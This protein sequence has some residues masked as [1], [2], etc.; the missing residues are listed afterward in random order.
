MGEVADAEVEVLDGFPSAA[1]GTPARSLGRSLCS[2]HKSTR[3]FRM[4]LLLK[5][6]SLGLIVG[7]TVLMT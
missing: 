3:R 5:A 7:L 6:D 1:P 2:E 4:P